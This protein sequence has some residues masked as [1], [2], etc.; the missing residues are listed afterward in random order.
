LPDALSL[1]KNY[2]V[3]GDYVVAGVGLRGRGDATGFA[4]GNITVSGV[5]DGADIVAA[6][7]YWEAVE[8]KNGVSAAKGF[9][10]GYEVTG[11]A[12]GNDHAAPCWSSGGATGSSN[13][14]HTLRMYRAQVRQLLPVVNGK[15]Q[16]KGSFEVRLPDSGSN[17][18]GVPLTE[19]ASLVV[20]YRVISPLFPLK[21]V[22]IYDGAW[23]MNRDTE[24]M[25]QTIK[26]FY[27]AAPAVA[28]TRSAARLTHIAGNGQSNFGEEL[29]FK[30]DST[31]Y[32]VLSQTAEGV[33][34]DAA[35]PFSGRAG[36]AWDNLTFDV[37]SMVA[38]DSSVVYTRVLPTRSKFDCLSWGVVVFSTP[39]KDSDNDGL[40]DTWEQ[41][42]GYTDAKDGTAVALPGA[43]ASRK[44]IFIE[45]DYLK[46][47]G[48]H[49]HLPKQ[50]A[51][52]LAGEA[53]K[54]NGYQIHFD[55]GN[56]YQNGDQ[57]I[58]PYAAPSKPTDGRGGNAIDED[59]IACK[60]SPSKLCQFPNEPGA[61]SWKG[62][63][64]FFKNQ[65]LNY[66]DEASCAAHS[67]CVR[68]FAFARAPSY[69]Y[70]LFAHVLALPTTYWN[71]AGGTLVSIVDA[72]N[73]ATVTTSTPHGLAAG[74]RVSVSGAISDFDLNRT[75]RVQTTP[76]A[77]AFT[78]TTVNV[79]DGVYNSPREPGLGVASGNARSTSG[80]SDFG[81]GDSM[82]TLGRWLSDVPTDDQV[83]SAVVQAGT[84]A[85]EIGHTLAGTHGGFKQLN[86]PTDF[87]PTFEV[88]CKPNFL[89][90]MNYLFQVRGLPGGII[91]FSS[92][93]LPT[94]TESSLIEQNGLGAVAP[95]M[96]RWYSPLNAL[97]QQVQSASTRH[98]DGTLVA[99]GEL[100]MVR[101][102]GA[103]VAGG[104]P[105]PIDW[106]RNGAIS[107]TPI[108]QDLNYSGPKPGVPNSAATD[109]MAGFSD[110][111][112]FDLRQI[113]ARKNALG[114]SAGVWGSED[115]IGGGSED[116][117]GGGS[118]DII[119]GGSEDI[120]GGGSEDL[121]GGGEMTF[122]LANADVDPPTGL[123]A[124]TAYATVTLSWVAPAFGQ[125]RTYY[126]WR[127]D[128]T[129]YPIS[130]T[131]LP[132]NIA[133][134]EGAPPAT[135]FKDTTVQKYKKYT[136]FVT[137]AL[138]DGTKSGPSTMVTIEVK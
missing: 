99:S 103:T 71:I 53:F 24:F 19:G 123:T 7:L 58:V 138:G 73:T 60:D 134:V 120:V 45:I 1:F 30:G 42:Q 18:A 51:L 57:Y 35:N 22:L 43:N 130:A 3:T 10:R 5:P 66:A 14:A 61:I 77:T 122:D 126:I 98:C 129:T 80:W 87:W 49:S 17:G 116:L 11:K 34:L 78:I 65:P 91:D 63:F 32:R 105:A 41:N 119:G 2:F 46:K 117:I 93:K 16:A 118:E 29:S 31:G 112:V 94:L 84:L 39:V 62:G 132:T 9:F 86:A 125:I 33:R 52:D 111:E 95:Y 8:K 83:G 92:Q 128:T 74:T 69:H 108:T 137:S 114:F 12:L 44:D 55:V 102:E 79:A 72:N 88:N 109:I 75:Y 127:A 26:G 37:S 82:V 50:A 135:T 115:I 54:R 59:A 96:T 124:T 47:N 15:P 107:T 76:S 89:S 28:G 133:K 110:V 6:F 97:D 48:G 20:I 101:V 85:H 113:G 81:G 90:I 13:G 4:K 104:N 68:R 64:S 121:I 131:N 56:N 40:L 67:D 70:A 136:Y 27:Q 23:T 36:Y 100:Q 25:S 38:P 21:A 106:N